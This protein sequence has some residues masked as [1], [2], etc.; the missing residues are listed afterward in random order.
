[1]SF[2]SVC[3]TWAHFEWGVDPQ[4]RMKYKHKTDV[5]GSPCILRLRQA[6]ASDLSQ[7][8]LLETD[9]PDRAFRYP[10][11][12]FM[13]SK[14]RLLPWISDVLDHLNFD[15]ARD[16]FSGSGCVSYLLKAL[17]KTSLPTTS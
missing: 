17:G 1:M 6:M 5:L 13:G 14:Y 9:F 10:Q 7:K 3:E 16:A 2:P 8:L 12:R 15:T 11:L 4:A